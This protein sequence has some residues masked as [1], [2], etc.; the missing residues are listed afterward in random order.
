VASFPTPV[1]TGPGA[2]PAS[3]TMSTV[4]YV[5]VKWPEVSVDHPPPY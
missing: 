1:K 2:H 3:H 4:S 5:G